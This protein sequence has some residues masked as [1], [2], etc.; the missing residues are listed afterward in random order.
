MPNPFKRKAPKPTPPPKDDS[1]LQS[2]SDAGS[3]RAARLTASAL[4]AVGASGIPPAPVDRQSVLP[5]AATQQRETTP[6]SQ[7]K[8]DIDQDPADT[9]WPLTGPKS[10]AASSSPSDTGSGGSNAESEILFILLG[11]GEQWKRPKASRTGRPSVSEQYQLYEAA[12]LDCPGYWNVIDYENRQEFHR[13]IWQ[14]AKNRNV[15]VSKA[16][17]DFIYNQWAAK[18]EI[19]PFLPDFE[20]ALAPIPFLDKRPAGPETRNGHFVVPK[21]WDQRTRGY[22]QDLATEATE[23]HVYAMC[24]AKQ[25]RDVLPFEQLPQFMRRQRIVRRPDEHSDDL[26]LRSTYAAWLADAETRSLVNPL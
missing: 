7:E 9:N 23:R 3:S 10:K 8:D 24:I 11:P 22:I 2:T 15:Y 20:K 26:T 25:D 4:L 1:K 21:E 19:E 5:L 6:S 17:T 18:K 13:R 14:L 12:K 16:V